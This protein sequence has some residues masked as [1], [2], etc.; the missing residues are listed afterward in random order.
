[1]VVRQQVT[2]RSVD[3]YYVCQTVDSIVAD[4][5]P[6]LRN[7]EDIFGDTSVEILLRRFPKWTAFHVFIESIVEAIIWEDADRA[8]EDFL[9]R[10]PRPTRK[11]WVDRLLSS[12]GLEYS[13]LN[14][15]AETGGNTEVEEYLDFLAE[16]GVMAELL[17]R[18]T[19]QTFWVLFANRRLLRDFGRVV[20][21]YVAAATAANQLSA[22]SR[23]CAVPTWAKDAVFHRDK[24]KCV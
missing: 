6:Y 7:I 14:F 12:N 9:P 4:P 23:R 1:M 3:L 10:P 20:S 11:P 22:S 24:G 19:T 8:L 18:V 16:N 17:D 21:H 15:V 2:L 5:S 13:L